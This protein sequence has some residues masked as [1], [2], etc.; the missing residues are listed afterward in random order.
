M[1]REHQ[2][3]AQGYQGEGQ[4]TNA[5]FGNAGEGQ[6]LGAGGCRRTRSGKGGGQNPGGGAAA[7]APGAVR[8]VSRTVVRTPVVSTGGRDEPA[9]APDVEDVAP[10]VEDVET[11]S[12]AEGEVTVVVVVVV[13]LK[14][15]QSI[16]TSNPPAK[17]SPGPRG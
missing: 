9:E 12:T 11:S 1:R 5:P 8:V 4:A 13:G 14:G 6:R 7:D 3:A 2:Q 10:S 15:G 17:T 16:S